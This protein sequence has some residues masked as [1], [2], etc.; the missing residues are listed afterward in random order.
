MNDKETA[1][2]YRIRAG[3]Y[4]KI[5]YREIPERRKEIDDEVN[6][7]RTLA[8]GKSV[9]ELACGTGYWT[10]VMSQSAA[11]ITAVDLWPEMLDEARKKKLL[12]PVHFQAGDMFGLTIPEAQFDL[13]AVG[14]WFSHQP[15]QEY[16]RFF[17]LVTR[18]LKPSGQIWLIE[19]NP[20]A[21]GT[22]HEMVRTDQ[23]G[24]NFKRRHLEDGSQHVILK[25]YFAE[26][27]LRAIFAPRFE[28]RELIYKKYYWSVRLSPRS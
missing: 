17:D 26:D 15:R 19:N 20:P 11:E 23:F 6:R 22:H 25:N 12:C 10:E 28:L 5:Y 1:D 9:L 2:Y 18:P 3:E 7:L 14:F 21:E 27:E 24:N 8:T 13:V 4:E 16:D